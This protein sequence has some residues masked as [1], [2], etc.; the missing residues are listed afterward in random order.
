M[1]LLRK[2]RPAFL[3]AL[4]LPVLL[5]G[6][7]SGSQTTRINRP[8][9]SIPA[10]TPGFEVTVTPAFVATL[11]N[12]PVIVTIIISPEPGFHDNVRLTVSGGNGSFVVQNP[13]PDTLSLN[14]STPKETSFLVSQTLGA[15]VGSAATL[16]VTATTGAVTRTVVITAEAQ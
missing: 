6:C 12:I 16:T 5:C 4:V 15:R 14:G 9:T 11:P 1:V 10:V 8:L 2:I 7:G 3:A 13:T